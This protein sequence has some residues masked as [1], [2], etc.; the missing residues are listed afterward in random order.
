[1]KENGIS[2][3][4]AYLGLVGYRSYLKTKSLKMVYTET[5][6]IAINLVILSLCEKGS[7][8][9]VFCKNSMNI[10]PDRKLSKLNVKMS[11]YVQSDNLCEHVVRK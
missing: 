1:M 7:C 6:E 3:E 10:D 4:F 2:K 9:V 8:L 11:F 5:R